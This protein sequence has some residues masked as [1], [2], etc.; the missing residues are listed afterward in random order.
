VSGLQYAYAPAIRLRLR[1][2]RCPLVQQPHVSLSDGFL[3]G[4]GFLGYP[5]PSR[6]PAWSPSPVQHRAEISLRS[7]GLRESRDGLLCSMCPFSVTVGRHSTPRPSHRGDT[8]C[9]NITWP[10]GDVSRLGLPLAV[11][12]VINHDA[13]VPSSNIL[14][15]VTCWGRSPH[16]ASSLSPFHP[17]TSTLENQSHAGG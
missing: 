7:S 3:A 14:S 17:C 1:L 4:L 6:H 15:R 8:M 16:P 9:L 2:L 11:R 5:P 12:Q 13:Y 10:N